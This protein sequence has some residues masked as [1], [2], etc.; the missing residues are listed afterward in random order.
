MEEL[1]DV[2]DLVT[3][4]RRKGRHSLRR[5]ALAYRRADYLSL[6]VV[7]DHG[8]AQKIGSGS[9]PGISA[10]AKSTIRAENLG[11]FAGHF[12]VRHP[13]QA[14]KLPRANCPRVFPV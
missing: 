2:A 11:P 4:Q 7:Q 8:R 10:V 5:P 6:V 14:K 13:A 1:R 12:G 9:A 3:G